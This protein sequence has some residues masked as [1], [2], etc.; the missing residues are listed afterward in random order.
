MFAL[1]GGNFIQE[2]QRRRNSVASAAGAGFLL[3]APDNLRWWHDQEFGTATHNGGEKYLIEPINAKF[4]SWPEANAQGGR[5]YA[6]H[7]MHPGVPPAAMIRSILDNIHSYVAGAVSTALLSN[8]FN[9][10][11]L[12]GVLIDSIGPEVKR[13]I[14][15]SIAKDYQA[16]GLTENS[17]AKRHLKYSTQKL[18]YAH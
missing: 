12:Q 5:R 11:E 8:D 14:V 18:K 7:V 15:E 9:I 1:T 4:L 3:W 13:M 6:S 17:A 2:L 10:A 16:P